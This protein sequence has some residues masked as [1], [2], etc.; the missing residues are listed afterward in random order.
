LQNLLPPAT[1]T[2][3]VPDAPHLWYPF[4]P[5]AGAKAIL[6]FIDRH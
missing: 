6:Q 4:N 2:A 1:Q 5:Q 3:V